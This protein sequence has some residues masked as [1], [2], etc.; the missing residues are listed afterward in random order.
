[1]E[2]QMRV[3]PVKGHEFML[4]FGTI[5]SSSRNRASGPYERVE[6]LRP[7]IV[8]LSPPLS[9][10]HPPLARHQGRVNVWTFRTVRAGWHEY[11]TI[12][13]MII[14]HDTCIIPVC[15]FS[16]GLSPLYCLY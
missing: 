11:K 9:L 8:R 12:H 4:D 2:G 13:Y 10:S 5:N 1:M 16:I 15:C 6:L 7:V 3:H 14:E